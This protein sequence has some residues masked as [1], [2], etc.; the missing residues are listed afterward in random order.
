MTTELTTQGAKE[1]TI[2]SEQIDLIK[3]TVAKGATDQELQLF[4]YDCKRRGIHPLDRL[5]HF[6]KR[7]G[8]YT[9]VTSIDFMR[10]R[11]HESNECAGIDDAVFNGDPDTLGFTAAVTVYRMVQGVRCPFTA[12]ARWSEYKPEPGESGKGDVMWRKMPH[13][14][15]SKCAE[16]LALRRAFPAQLAGLYEVSELDQAD[17]SSKPATPPPTAPTPTDAFASMVIKI[18][19][20]SGEKEKIKDGKKTT[21]TW[22]RYAIQL[23]DE[24]YYSTFD[25]KIAEDA[26]R[27]RLEALPVEVVAEQGQ[28]G[29]NIKTL[30]IAEPPRESGQEG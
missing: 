27:A 16:A 20:Q 2:S 24:K 19:R 6:T 26:D 3:E 4:L 5:L 25:K 12:T 9:P 17:R 15:L 14:M 30:V 23:S 8:R 28:Y 22:T 13:T 21:V 1:I 11:A 18:D 29:L 10:T 7:S